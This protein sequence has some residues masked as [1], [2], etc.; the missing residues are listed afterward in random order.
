MPRLSPMTTDFSGKIPWSVRARFD[1]KIA[2]FVL[3][4]RGTLKVLALV[5]L[6]D[7]T[8]TAKADRQCAITKEG[9]LG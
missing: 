8:H 1:R 6:D 9:R 3:C 5:E 2:D 7:R 4:E